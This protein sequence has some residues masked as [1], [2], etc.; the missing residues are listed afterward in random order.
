MRCPQ[1]DNDSQECECSAMDYLSIVPFYQNLL[2]NCCFR[3]IGP[4]FGSILLNLPPG[5]ND[6]YF[7]NLLTV[8][9]DAVTVST[10]LV[11]NVDNT[12][13]LGL[14]TLRWRDFY[15]GP[16]TINI[17]GPP[18]SA[19]P[20]LIG[21]DPAGV[22]NTQFGFSTPFINV[23]PIFSPEVGALGGWRISSYSGFEWPR[24]NRA[25]KFGFSCGTFWTYF[26]LDLWKTRTDG[27]DG[28]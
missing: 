13:S 24:S 5:S 25:T 22:I 26:F 27:C 17:A 11:P 23:G 15:V 19:N 12:L 2:N 16:G 9:P 20:G 1:C 28:T 14:E 18:G 21:S 8:S 3:V 10:A 6:V 7:S 4:G